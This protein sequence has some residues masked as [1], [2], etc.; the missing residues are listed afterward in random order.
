MAIGVIA[1]LRVHPGKGGEF[2]AA[3]ARQAEAV[4]QNEPG[5]RLYRLC[6]SREDPNGYIVMEIYD[7]DGD[8]AAHRESAHMVANRPVMAPLV[9]ERLGVE[10]YDA[11]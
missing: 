4:R 6:R 11:V 5:N 7:S 9:A 3:F 10:I 1:R 2:E 8:L